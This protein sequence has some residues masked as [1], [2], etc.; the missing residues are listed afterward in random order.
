M[1]EFI[2][3]EILTTT[4]FGLIIIASINLYYALMFQFKRNK[5]TPPGEI[6]ISTF[7]WGIFWM[8]AAVWAQSFFYLLWDFDL[9]E[10]RDQYKLNLIP[11]G[12]FL[13]G[14]IY[15][16]NS[17]ELTKNSN[18]RFVIIASLLFSMLAVFVLSI[19]S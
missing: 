18:F 19:F 16:F 2:T 13:V 10:K 15:I 1:G 8:L 12:S 6:D 3:S 17:L 11:R 7:V 9:I 5:V 4:A 14:S